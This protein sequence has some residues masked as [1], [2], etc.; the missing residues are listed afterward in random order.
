MI[1]DLVKQIVFGK[2]KEKRQAFVKIWNLASKKG[3]YPSS[4]NDFYLARGKGKLPLNFTVPAINLRGLTYDVAQV[5]FKLAKEK[6]IG[7]FILEIARSEMGYTGQ[8]PFEYA[9]VILGA[10]IK[11][12]FSGPV[13]VQGDHF[14][15]KPDKITGKTKSGEVEKIKKL[16]KTSIQAGF[17]N[18][19]IDTS[20]L[21]DL[22]KKTID[23]QQKANY[24]L[25]A[26]LALYCRQLQ[27]KGIT[28]SLGGE[29]GEVG[30]KNSTE[31][32]LRVYLDGFNKHFSK[33][34]IGLSKVSVQTGT[35]HGGVVLADGS[36]AKVDV[37]F[38]T[39][40]KLAQTA[41][42]YGL[43]GTVQHGASTLPENYFKEFPKSEAIEVHLATEFQNIILN[44]QK[45][46]KILL[47]KMYR[48]LD[49]EKVPEHKSGQTLE[50]FHY[51][52][53]K[54]AWGQFKKECF[55]LPEK[56][57]KPIMANLAKKF[58]FIFKSLNVKNTRTMVNAIIRPVKIIK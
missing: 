4:I 16:I 31:E 21:V 56:I 25:T 29:I 3:I 13:F 27:P 36:L 51:S 18:I 10:A 19:D 33:K 42:S 30:S 54:K 41:R 15:V 22:T 35:H 46:P 40:R 39:L 50:Q 24:L 20:T 1:D 38:G 5:I 17:Y 32:E 48:W 12:K 9:G 52:L 47:K 57:K 7:A 49:K 2:E 53:R 14:Q 58:S 8:D 6:N 23:D 44:H 34:L 55:Y 37:D 11:Q 43:S 45:F 26:K 28:I